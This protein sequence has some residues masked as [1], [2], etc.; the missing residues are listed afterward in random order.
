MIK[1]ACLL[2]VARSVIQIKRVASAALLFVVGPFDVALIMACTVMLVT[3]IIVRV[4]EVF[5]VAVLIVHVAVSRR[6]ANVTPVRCVYWRDYRH[7][8]VT[9]ISAKNSS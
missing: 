7:R 9:S 8:R 4:G 2:T 1:I 5:L 6:A 3:R